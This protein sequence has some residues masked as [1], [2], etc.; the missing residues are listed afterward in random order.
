MRHEVGVEMPPGRLIAKDR[1]AEV[2][3]SSN[4]PKSAETGHGETACST[5]VAAMDEEG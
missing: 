3:P 1:I 4:G 2:M 5:V